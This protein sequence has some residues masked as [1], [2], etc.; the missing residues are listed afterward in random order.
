[1]NLGTLGLTLGRS[2]TNLWGV[3]VLQRVDW[4]DLSPNQAANCPVC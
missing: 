3:I 2:G 1:M 4:L